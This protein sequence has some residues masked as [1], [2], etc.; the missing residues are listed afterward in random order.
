LDRLLYLLY[1]KRASIDGIWEMLAG[2]RA[3]LKGQRF[4]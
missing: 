4:I 3:G 2:E 1:G